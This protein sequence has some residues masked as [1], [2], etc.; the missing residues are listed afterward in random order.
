MVGGKSERMRDR[1]ADRSSIFL[2][3]VGRVIKRQIIDCIGVYTG[4]LHNDFGVRPQT[5]RIRVDIRIRISR[6]LSRPRPL[7]FSRHRPLSFTPPRT[8]SSVPKPSRL[9]LHPPTITFRTRSQSCSCYCW[10][11]WRRGMSACGSKM[12]KG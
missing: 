10:C 2:L 9:T 1:S 12:R 8:R 4:C 5:Y 7:P 6:Q 3:F 11:F